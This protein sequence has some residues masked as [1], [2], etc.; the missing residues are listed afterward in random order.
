M[1]PA[2][3]A[4]QA[5]GQNP[6]TKLPLSTTRRSIRT[7]SRP[8]IAPKTQA[9]TIRQLCNTPAS[10]FPRQ[11]LSFRQINYLHMGLEMLPISIRAKE[12]HMDNEHHI[13]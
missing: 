10:I 1:L 5:K 11:L 9:N 3:D 4:V 7:I 12:H 8:H 6:D 13:T 2:I